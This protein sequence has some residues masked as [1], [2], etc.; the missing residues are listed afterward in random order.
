MDFLED[1]WW[2]LIILCYF[3]S[4]IY[5]K[6][7]DISNKL[8]GDNKE[9]A[10]EAASLPGLLPEG[11]WKCENCGKLHPDTDSVCVCGASRPKAADPKAS[12]S[13]AAPDIVDAAEEIRKY[14]Q[15]FDEGILTQ[16]EFDAKKKQLLGL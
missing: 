16:E 8:P 2:V 12:E 9:K 11:S 3:I 15:L 1:Y 14:K 5:D 7:T 6:V 4:S 10:E 13:K